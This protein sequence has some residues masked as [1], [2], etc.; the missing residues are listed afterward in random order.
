LELRAFDSN[1]FLKRAKMKFK[2][3]H[4][5][6]EQPKSAFAEGNARWTNKDM[7]PVPKEE[8]K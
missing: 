8:R 3:P 7:D 5:K 2:K 1:N 6:V 4:L